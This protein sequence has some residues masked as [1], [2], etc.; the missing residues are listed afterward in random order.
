MHIYFKHMGNVQQ[1]RILYPQNKLKKKMMQNMFSDKKR[2]K[3]E[4]KQYGRRRKI[5]EH[6]EIKQP[7]TGK[8]DILKE[9]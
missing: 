4:V 8:R 9:I 2:I 7:S 1:D 5:S 6:L 3:L